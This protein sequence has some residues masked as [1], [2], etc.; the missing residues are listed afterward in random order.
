MLQV[1]MFA[2]FKKCLGDVSLINALYDI[3][4]GKYAHS[5][6]LIRVY[7]DKGNPDAAEQLKKELPAITLSATYQK[8]RLAA[9]I[10]G[11]N[12]LIIIDFDDLPAADLSRLLDLA[13]QA[14]YT[15]AC[16]ISPRG[17]GI[18]IIAYP[19]VRLPRTPDNH[20]AVF[21]LVKEWYEQLLGVA[22]DASGSDI[23]RLCLLSYDPA[24]FLSPRF[25]PWLK[26]EAGEPQGLP[27]IEPVFSDK[28]LQLLASARKKASRKFSYAEGNRN[29]YV[30]L[31]ASHCN[32]LGVDKEAMADYA[33]KAFADLPADERMAAIDSAYVHTEQHATGG[34]RKT[35]RKDGFVEQIQAFLTE[36]YVLHRNVVR[37]QVEYRAKEEEEES[38]TPVTDYWENSVWCALQKEGVL[39]HLSDLR[40]VIH[41]D[42]SPEYDPFCSYLEQLPPWDRRT[43]PIGRLAA[44][45][46]T[47]RPEFWEK[48]FRKWLVA[49]VACAADKRAENHSVLM[50]SGAQGLGK[51][52]WL[53]NLVPP[54]LR[55]YVYSGNLDPT[56][57]D[58]SLMM[59]DCFLIILDELSGQS[60]TELNRLKALITK[61]SVYE[62]RPYARNAETYVRRASFAATVNDSEVLTDRT[63]SRRFLCFEATQIDYS[64]PV[65]YTGIYAQ[66]LALF[67]DGFR[68]WFADADIAEINDNNE[69]FQQ[70]CPEAELFYT[71]FR[72]P[73]R[74]E[75][76]LLLTCSEIVA[77][78]AEK[79]RYPITSTGVNILGKMLKRDGFLCQKRHGKRL[80]A[81]IELTFD[82]VEARRKGFGS[83][84]DDNAEGVD[85][86][87]DEEEEG[88]DPELAF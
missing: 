87:D 43:D 56:A 52:T 30:H 88:G 4:G 61:N 85:K 66:A 47:T 6:N 27:L 33:S 74:F 54:R 44:T 1:T 42:F 35:H 5:V 72:K 80:Y 26:G 31:M 59:S 62:R 79:T 12:P 38:Y 25:E 41:S 36:H 18:K 50:L 29:N 83:Y 48:C 67:R 64:S 16:W 9:Y 13:R 57:K 20:P 3:R 78:I 70:L 46:N 11:Y 32:R 8:K 49:L 60:R 34:G 7:M 86:E 22:A 58:S 17:H 75:L 63:G 37:R 76:P 19:A 55:G 69:P 10:T 71:Y 23:G 15:V 84:P 51:T 81:V 28:T 2:K 45:V 24:L 73:I 82:Q 65:D 77:K 68:Y 40:A 14:V 21:K 53:R 39:C